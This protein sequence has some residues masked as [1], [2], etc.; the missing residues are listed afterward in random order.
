MKQRKLPNLRTMV[1]LQAFTVL[2]VP[3]YFLAILYVKMIGFK[4]MLGIWG[5]YCIGIYA[6]SRLVKQVKLVSD[7]CAIQTLRAAESSCLH[8]A[9]I[10][11]TFLV[12]LLAANQM[13]PVFPWIV[14][15]LPIVLTAGL[16]LIY[17]ERAILFAYWDKKGLPPC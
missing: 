14:E 3:A 12:I 15:H 4:M 1:F 16:F 13:E 9:E 5:V 11:I 17:L 10:V 8:S 6:Q 2:L 7:E